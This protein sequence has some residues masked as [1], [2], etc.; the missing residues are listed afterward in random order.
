MGGVPP[1]SFGLM[2]PLGVSA[3]EEEKV[4]GSF[5]LSVQQLRQ[6]GTFVWVYFL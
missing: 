6:K 2:Q 3:G 5:L 4:S 1:Q